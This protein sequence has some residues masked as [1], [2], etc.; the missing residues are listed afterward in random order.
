MATVVLTAVG[1]LIGGP[2]GAAV[3]GLL[4]Q[5]IDRRLL[6]PKGRQGPRLTELKVQ[7][8]SYGTPLP[9]LFGTMRVAGSVIWSTDLAEHRSRQSA[10]KG[11]PKTTT[12]S[13]SA[14]LAVALSARPIL[15]VGRIWADGNLLRGAAGD[16]KTKPG[17]FRL[18][19]GGEDQA[20]DP[21]IA[22]A[23]G[24]ALAPAHRGVAYA[25]F[26][27]LPLADFGNRVPSLT[28]EVTADADAPGAGAIAA[29]LGGGAVVDGGVALPIAGFSAYG[30]SARGV[31]ELL[32]DASGARWTPDGARLRM[33][34]DAGVDATV[35]DAGWSADG[36]DGRGRSL[37]PL[38]TV[39][40]ALSVAHYDPARD[41]Q[42]G[43]QAATRP[44][45]GERAEAVELPAALAAG[46][47]RGIAEAMLARAEAGRLR[48][49]AAAP[50][51][52]LAVRPGDAV[53]IAGEAGLWRVDATVLE[54]MAVRLELVPLLPGSA[55]AP[56]ASPGRV[57]AAPDAV[58]GATRLEAFELP[59]PDE[60]L[61]TAPRL[62]VVAAGAGAGWRGAAL[63]VS[64]DGGAS[65]A[66]AGT[67]AAPAVLGQVAAAPPAAAATLADARS[68]LEVELAHAGMALADA[69]ARRLDAGANLALVGDELLQFA[70]A[71][72]LGG[73]RWRLTGLWRGRLGTEAA[74]GTAAAGD[75]F[76]LLEADAART[77]DLPGAAAGQT[78]RVIASGVGDGAEGAAADAVLTGA[79]VRPPA[80]VHLR[81]ERRGDTRWLVWTRRSRAGWRWRDGVDAPLGEE[82][83]LYRVAVGSRVAEV[84]V[85]ELALLPGEAGVARVRQVGTAGPSAAAAIDLG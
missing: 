40:K 41:W 32:A 2:I 62:T 5:G 66:D 76:V 73:T 71:E 12:Y 19:A 29:A 55:P 56:A 84:T 74:I 22:A 48:R 58:A 46:A 67:T 39:P 36:R 51:A 65:W 11:Q 63:I 17:G 23:E 80:P 16:W 49:T 13:Y 77:V 26:E 54:A 44:G 78:V 21:L 33:R 47:A 50:L 4:G 10:G 20:A 72:P 6:A 53:A 15:R 60:T 43:V 8:S 9:K 45:P 1:G 7:T 35:A 14:C 75:R 3:G 37:A 30:D 82:R 69:D 79:S 42:A 59:A 28:F 68:V 81:V 64:T 24:A 31:L 27:D 85:P 25:V 18:H 61:T 83:E 34:A 38:A 57:V 70:R 52:A